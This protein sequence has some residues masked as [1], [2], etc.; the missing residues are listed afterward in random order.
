MSP[1]PPL[2]PILSLASALAQQALAEL[3][4]L[5][6]IPRPCNA[7]VARNGWAVTV[8]VAP[9]PTAVAPGL[10]LTDCERHVV[11]VLATAQERWTTARIQA[12]LDRR[13][14]IHGECTV[15]RALARLQR[16]PFSLL[17]N[18][19]KVP[20]GY[21]LLSNLPLFQRPPS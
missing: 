19:R 11:V 20:Q 13:G 3:I 7:T 6:A 16:P 2:D 15:S 10:D 14:F 21:W 17:G 9:E 5:G 12:E 4:E 18:S 1:L 8:T